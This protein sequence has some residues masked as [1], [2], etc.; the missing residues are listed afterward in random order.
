MRRV[1]RERNLSIDLV[2]LIDVVFILLLFFL[3]STSFKK[4][5]QILSIDLPEVSENG[6][7]EKKS[8]EEKKELV[9]EIK[10]GA[11]SLNGKEIAQEELEGQL[12]KNDQTEQYILRIDKKTPF[13]EV[14]E[15]LNIFQK[16][17]KTNL[18]VITEIKK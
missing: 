2:P 18:T 6:S 13:D 12:Q 8:L 7:E 1:R 9:L 15:V 16:N 11:L 3:A 4:K 14:A 10:E 5:E 17:N